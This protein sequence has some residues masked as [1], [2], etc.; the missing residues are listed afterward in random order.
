MFRFLIN[1]LKFLKSALENEAQLASISTT[2]ELQGRIDADLKLFKEHLGESPDVNYR[3]FQLHDSKKAAII[4]IDGLVDN[5]IV[6]EQILK[7]LMIQTHKSDAQKAGTIEEIKARLVPVGGVKE[8]DELNEGVDA[9]LR[10]E[11]AL[12]VEGMRGAILVSAPGWERRTIQEPETEVIVKGP[13]EGFVETLRTNTALLRR[14]V[15]DPNLTFESMRIGRKTRTDV[16]IA[17]I[18]GIVQP[19]LVDEVRRRLKRIKT[20]AILAAGFIEQF[21]EDAPLSFFHTISYTERPDVL[22]A[23]IMEGRV[24]IFIEGTPVVDTVPMLFIESFQSPDDY[25]FRPYYS[26]MIRWFRYLAFGLSVFSPAVYVALSTYHQEMIPTPLLISMAA[27]TEGTPFPVVIEAVGMGLI[28]EVLREAGIRLPRPVGQAISIV[29][30]LVI[31]EA[32]VSAGFVSAPMVIIVALTAIASFAVPKQ[33]ESGAVLRLLLTFL[34]GILG[35]YGILIGS[36]IILAHLSSIRSFG[37]P[38]LAPI[39][40]LITNDLKDVLVRAPI[41]A[42][43]TRPDSIDTLDPKRQD[44]RLAPRAPESAPKKSENRWKERR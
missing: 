22:A 29:G 32:A 37:V 5:T 30:A 18:K 40:P 9:V 14:K 2:T 4:F 21:I 7:P 24:A 23:K 25:S 13:H 20:D 10:G 31:G 6:H 34:A 43:W 38:Y 3:E 41:W 19:E 8:I 28:F 26:S 33:V 17:Y 36:L 11:T 27:A 16:S 42:M 12:I 44:F 39:S 1:K 35:F 15:K